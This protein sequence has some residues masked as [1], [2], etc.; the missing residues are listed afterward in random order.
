M[1]CEA[2]EWVRIILC[3]VRAH[4]APIPVAAEVEVSCDRGADEGALIRGEPL[5]YA[6]RGAW[7]IGDRAACARIRVR[8]EP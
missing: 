2:H 1:G 7:V 3:Q 8:R 4:A 6:L 5:K